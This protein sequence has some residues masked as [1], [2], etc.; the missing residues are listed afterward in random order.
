MNFSNDQPSG[1]RVKGD[2]FYEVRDRARDA[3]IDRL[4]AR[5]LDAVSKGKDY[6]NFVIAAGYAAFFGLWAGVASDIGVRPRCAAAALMGVSLM[7][8]IGWEILS[9]YQRGKAAKA[10]N[11]LCFDVLPRDEFEQKWD[12]AIATEHRISNWYIRAWT[13]VLWPTVATGLSGAAILAGAAAAKGFG[14]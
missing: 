8:F 3:R 5:H 2:F 10:F 7:M 9:M 14:L 11:D 1:L 6:T 13:W 4:Q 12:A